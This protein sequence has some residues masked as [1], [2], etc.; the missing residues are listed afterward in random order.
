M[1]HRREVCLHISTTSCSKV[2]MEQVLN[3]FDI[4]VQIHTLVDKWYGET[5]P[6]TDYSATIIDGELGMSCYRGWNE[7]YRSADLGAKYIQ[8][9]GLTTSE[10]TWHVVRFYFHSYEEEFD[11][12]VLVMMQIIGAIMVLFDGDCFLTDIYFYTLG[13]IRRKGKVVLGR[14][15]SWTQQEAD[16]LGLPYSIEDLLID[17]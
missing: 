9:H 8:I 6:H 11:K 1:L 12:A 17:D 15:W 2:I 5:E 10:G 14:Y 16:A 3:V 4:D 13:L 7:A